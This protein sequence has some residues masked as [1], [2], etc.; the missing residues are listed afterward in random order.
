MHPM[1][2]KEQARKELN[3]IDHKYHDY[4]YAKRFIAPGSKEHKKD[5]DRKQELLELLGLHYWQRTKKEVVGSGRLPESKHR[6]YV[7]EAFE[8]GKN[9]PAQVL[10]DYPELVSK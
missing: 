9:I 4:G 8:A 3:A 7:T 2:S 1:L 10:A 5:M 6:K